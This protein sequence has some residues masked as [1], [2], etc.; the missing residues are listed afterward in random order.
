VS[1]RSCQLRPRAAQAARHLLL[2]QLSA[3]ALL[4]PQQDEHG[5]AVSASEHDGD[6]EDDADLEGDGVEQRDAREIEQDG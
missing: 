6:D 1:G 2:D 3:P 4:D 5:G